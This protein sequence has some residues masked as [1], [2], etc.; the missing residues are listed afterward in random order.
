[1]VDLVH[2]TYGSGD[3]QNTADTHFFVFIKLVARWPVVEKGETIEW[4]TTAW[5]LLCDFGLAISL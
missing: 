1:M 4:G 2:L 5:R 3:F